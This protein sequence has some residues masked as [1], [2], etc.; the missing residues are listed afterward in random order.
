MSA[1]SDVHCAGV[2]PTGLSGL[3]SNVIV[4][5]TAPLSKDNVEK[6]SRASLDDRQSGRSSEPEYEVARP[7]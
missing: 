6:H 5:T 1:R 4:P 7:A 2:S 3:F